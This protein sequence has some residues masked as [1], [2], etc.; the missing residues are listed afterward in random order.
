MLD[1]LYRSLRDAARGLAR[2]PVF[3]IVAVLSLGLGIGANAAIFGL[4][5]A[6][7]LRPLPGVQDVDRVVEVADESFSYPAVRD[8]IAGAREAELAGY[9]ERALALNG[10]D[11]SERVE[12]VAVTG[13]YFG[14]LGVRPLRGRAL[15]ARDDEPG[16]PLVAVLSDATWRERFGGDPAVVGKDIVLNGQPFTVVGVAPRGFRGSRLGTR[17]LAWLS[18]AGWSRVKRGLYDGLD[19]SN[20]GWGWLSV[21]GRLA[22]TGTAAALDRELAA[23]QREEARLY[24]K[25]VPSPPPELKVVPAAA[26]AAG[27]RGSRDIAR[28]GRILMGAV[29]LA[30]VIACANVANLLLARGT[31]RRQEM[32]VR[33][34]LGASTAWIVTQSLAESALLASLG[35]VTGLVVASWGVAVLGGVTLP[36]GIDLG[37]SGVRISG[38][39]LGFAVAIGAVTAVLFGTLPALRATATRATGAL[40]A[41][42]A[43]DDPRGV[44][45]RSALVAL[46]LALCLVLLSGAGLLLRSLRAAMHTDLGFD[47]SHLA[48]LSVDLGN[49]GYAEARVRG[50]M[51][52]L[53]RRVVV[54]TEVEAA[55]WVSFAPLDPDEDRESFTLDA[56]AGAGSEYPHSEV[57]YTGPGYFVTTRTPLLSGRGYDENDRAAE[58]VVSRAFVERFVPGEVAIGR[59]LYMGRGFAATIV[60]VAEDVALHG[61]GARVQPLIYL[62]AP[63]ATPGGSASLLVRT[64]G[65]PAALLPVLA[66]TAQELDASLPLRSESLADRLRQLLTPQRVAAALFGVFSLL[67]LVLATTGIYGVVAYA[68]AGRVREFGIRVALGAT[69]A[70]VV[71]HVVAHGLGA[72]GV[73]V[74]LGIAGAWVAGRALRSLL[75]DIGPADPLSLAAATLLLC[76]AAAVALLIPALRATGI[77]AARALREE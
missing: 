10:V 27:L 28:F 46:Q 59:T 1:L 8:F 50:Y 34:A 5:D 70:R 57:R 54:R 7:V 71:R 61:P 48:L 6:L 52:E 73:G 45:S 74:A 63:G 22:P 23:M 77:D 65:E 58:A 13:D 3:T 38:R 60:G 33:R 4:I 17:P 66:A 72:V 41:R 62:Y 55:A 2:S 51:D 47:A 42:G 64:H 56:P 40:S 43:T 53:R 32:A 35:V 30:L 68:T 18:V 26:A 12:V 24:P 14:V 11:A 31:R 75:Y 15:E 20:R 37:A 19:V 25:Y 39:L 29:A 9:S 69:P 36:G 21:V 67:T 76:A 49:S 44:R 16:A